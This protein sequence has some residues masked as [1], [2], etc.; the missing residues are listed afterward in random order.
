MCRHRLCR[1][2]P[3]PRWP[4]PF[5]PPGRRTLLLGVIWLVLVNTMVRRSMPL[6]HSLWSA[7]CIRLW[8]QCRQGLP[9]LLQ[10]LAHRTDCCVTLPWSL[11]GLG[12]LVAAD[13]L[14][15]AYL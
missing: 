9:R 13:C 12:V 10:L 1:P 3:P 14:E 15:G 2:P 6:Q 11:R 8:D 7:A 5:W 4:W